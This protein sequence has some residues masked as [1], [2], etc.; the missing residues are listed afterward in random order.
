[1]MMMKMSIMINLTVRSEMIES[2]DMAEN[3]ARNHVVMSLAVKVIITMEIGVVADLPVT[4]TTDRGLEEK[5]GRFFQNSQ[6]VA[7]DGVLRRKDVAVSRQ[8]VAVG[9]EIVGEVVV[10][11]ETGVVV[12][13]V[14]AAVQRVVVT[15]GVGADL[16][17][18]EIVVPVHH[19]QTCGSK[20]SRHLLEAKVTCRF[21]SCVQFLSHQYQVLKTGHRTDLI[22]AMGLVV[23]KPNSL[24]AANTIFSSAFCV[25]YL[26]F[27]IVNV[28]Q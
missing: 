28:S 21:S 11:R 20:R 15:E 2:H 14:V 25:Y 9:Q 1:M 13:V 8:G 22:A 26:Q 6:I 12:V 24:P 19:Q 23:G 7:G 17:T 16:L 4:L 5:S 3:T 18:D 27:Y 10:V